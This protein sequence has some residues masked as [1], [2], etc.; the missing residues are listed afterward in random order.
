LDDTGNSIDKRKTREV[1]WRE[2]RLSLAHPKGSVSPTYGST[3]GDQDE[4]IDFH[5]LNFTALSVGTLD[6]VL[7]CTTYSVSSL[8][9]CEIII[10]ENLYYNIIEKL[11]RESDQ[12]F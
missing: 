1:R 3:L 5:I 9:P 2:A 8:W 7:Q 4:A 12:H 6:D 11:L 10:S